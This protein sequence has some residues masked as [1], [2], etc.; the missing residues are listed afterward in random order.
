MPNGGKTQKHIRSCTHTLC[1]YMT[2][3]KHLNYDKNI[4]VGDNYKRDNVMNTFTRS[5]VLKD[6]GTQAMR[7]LVHTH[8]HTH[9]IDNKVRTV[10]KVTVKRRLFILVTGH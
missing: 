10:V 2:K 7:S 4:V 6:S 5:H 1:V 9:M 8:T 3:R